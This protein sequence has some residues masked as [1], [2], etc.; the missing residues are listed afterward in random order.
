MH[1]S[2]C[3]HCSVMYDSLWPHGLQHS[4]LPCLSPS[5]G[6]CS[7]PCPLSQWCH[8][9]I[10]SSVIPFSSC[11]QSFPA[12]R[13]F[14]R[15]CT[16]HQVAK[17]S[18]G[19]SASVLPMNIQSWFPLKLTSWSPCSP[20]DSQESAPTLQFESIS[21]LVLSLFCCSALTSVHD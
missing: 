8:P 20:R 18:I 15:V 13:L 21:S 9:T 17:G 2:C 16:S 1:C 14:Q 5:P 19:V 7:N 10:S 12:S 4:R 6:A 11:P 3:C